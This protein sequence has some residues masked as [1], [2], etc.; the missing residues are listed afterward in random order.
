MLKIF[1]R[2]IKYVIQSQRALLKLSI[3]DI[4]KN[5]DTNSE[6]I[7]IINLLRGNYG[8]ELL[9]WDLSTVKYF[10]DNSIKFK[11]SRGKKKLTNKK[12]FWSPS[13]KF[14][15]NR[16][17]YS[18]KLIKYA[19][20]TESISLINPNS[21]EVSYLENKVFMYRKFNELNIRTPKTKILFEQNQFEK[22]IHTFPVLLKGAHSSGSMDIFKINKL[23]DLLEIAKSPKFIK[24]HKA[25]IIQELLNIRRDLRVVIIHGKIESYYWRI[26]HEKDWKPTSTSRGSSV[27]FQ[28][29]P[30]EWEAFILEEFNKLGVRMGAFDLAWDNDDLHTPPYILEFSPRFT[31][32]PPFLSNTK[33]NNYGER[34]RDTIGK[35]TYA[36]NQVDLIFNLNSKYLNGCR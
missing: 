33:N 34:K 4:L 21:Y 19:Q 20:E 31:P 23:D 13:E 29:F 17:N 10:T 30:K 16:E 35:D 1:K 27:D 8:I 28:N 36:I 25:F 9:C 26:N 6:N 24:K 22:E 14:F 5:Y 15:V 11:I 32:N 2:I 7:V 12:V 18:E 3:I